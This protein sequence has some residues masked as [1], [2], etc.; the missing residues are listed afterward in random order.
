M[1]R[2]EGGH[3]PA[4]RRLRSRDDAAGAGHKHLC[5]R[6]RLPLHPWWNEKGSGNRV[7]RNGAGGRFQR[8]RCATSQSPLQ[9]S[10]KGARGWTPNANVFSERPRPRAWAGTPDSMDRPAIGAVSVLTSAVG[11]QAMARWPSMLVADACLPDGS[12]LSPPFRSTGQIDPRR[13]ARHLQPPS[14][15]RLPRGR[16]ATRG[17]QRV[18][19]EGRGVASFDAARL[20]FAW[21][22]PYRCRALAFRTESGARGG[23]P[24]WFPPTA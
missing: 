20:V 12:N 18:Q 16:D 19:I 9:L 10:A 5:C 7:R 6:W 11:R 8:H 13:R 17:K 22:G 3:W 24:R 2:E 21:R 1:N 15:R 14:P 23:S 4:A